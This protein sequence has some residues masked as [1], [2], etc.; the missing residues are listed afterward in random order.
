MNHLR[1]YLILT[2]YLI[3]FANFQSRS[4]VLCEGLVI[5][6]GNLVDEDVLPLLEEVNLHFGLQFIG[7]IMSPTWS[8]KPAW[9]YR[10]GQRKVSGGR[11]NWEISTYGRRGKP[12]SCILLSW[13]PFPFRLQLPMIWRKLKNHGSFCV[14]QCP[15]IEIN[16]SCS[17]SSSISSVSSVVFHCLFNLP[18]ILFGLF[19]SLFSPLI[20]NQQLS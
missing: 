18:F 6:T 19:Y 1:D 13:F 20:F 15:S 5:N 4:P 11:P 17:C 7:A 12:S 16:V 2:W 3:R 10:S 9:D 8:E 14:F